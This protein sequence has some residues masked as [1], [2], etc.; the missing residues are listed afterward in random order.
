MDRESKQKIGYAA[1]GLLFLFLS[2]SILFLGRMSQERRLREEQRQ[3]LETI[4]PEIREELEENFEFYQKESM[5]EN[6]KFLPVVLLV[7]IAFGALLFLVYRNEEKKKK[8][9]I[10]EAVEQIYEQ[11]HRFHQGDFQIL[12]WNEET[13]EQDC[14]GRIHEKLRELGYY[15]SDMKVR[16]SEE[17]NNTK[18]LITDISHQLK[19]PLAS[20][21]MCHDLS[22]SEAL[23]QEER[24]EFLKTEAR[25]IRKLEMLLDELVK[26]S[27]LE[28][29]M[30]RVKPERTGLKQTISEA[31]S[32]VFMKAYEKQME[33]SVEI[34]NDI[35]VRHDRKWTV[36][37]LTNILENAVKYSGKG[38]GITIRV[39]RLLKNVLIEVE[40]EGMGI[41]EEELHK[42]FRRFY[43]GTQAKEQVKD[44][45]GVGLY[46][47][48]SIIEQQGGTILAKRKP[49]KGSIFNIIIPLE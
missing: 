1:V 42:I 28:S 49:E 3:E 4:Y 34:E 5:S 40:D 18:A 15:F 17:E 48:R 8:E 39:Q 20:I 38:T 2:I 12:S 30:I 9:L 6:V 27:R 31:V 13:N 11:L 21:R 25:E 35:Q 45:A 24:T 19:T 43:R 14:W 32:Q 7:I 44:G 33:I 36:E 22:G 29:N 26:L 16:L 46:L 10:Q 41:K 37:A 23:S 47:A